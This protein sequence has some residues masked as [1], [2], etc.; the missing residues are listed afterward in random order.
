MELTR[1]VGWLVDWLVAA[2][3]HDWISCGSS[4]QLFKDCS[5]IYTSIRSCAH[6]NKFLNHNFFFLRMLLSFLNTLAQIL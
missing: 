3:L 5:F 4:K 2:E 6:T 1:L